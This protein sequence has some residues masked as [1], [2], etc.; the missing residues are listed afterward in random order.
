[1]SIAVE[2]STGLVLGLDLAGT[3]MTPEE[4]DA[5]RGIR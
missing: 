4:F 2:A 3:R 5:S 1:M